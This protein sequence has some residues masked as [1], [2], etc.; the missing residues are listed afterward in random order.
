MRHILLMLMTFC[1]VQQTYSQK[2]N[3]QALNY[4]VRIWGEVS[5]LTPEHRGKED[6][7]LL[8]LNQNKTFSAFENTD[9]GPYILQIGN[10]TLKK[11]S[12]T[13]RVTK[14]ILA[15]KEKEYFMKGRILD[16]AKGKITYNIL[17]LE[18]NKFIIKAQHSD[19]TLI[20]KP[21]SLDYMPEESE[22]K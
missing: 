21:T 13:F 16:L 11:N 12:I 4:L 9:Y 20:F 7:V 15:G 8:K 3:Q 17:E 5:E 18:A 19:K 10:W 22:L 6:L 14:T 2:T 1:I